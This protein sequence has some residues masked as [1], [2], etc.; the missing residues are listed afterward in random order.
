MFGFATQKKADVNFSNIGAGDSPAMIE[1]KLLSSINNVEK[2]IKYY[3]QRVESINDRFVSIED[4]TQKQLSQADES[5]A[6]ILAKISSVK[7]GKAKG[8][9]EI[10]A[11][12]EKGAHFIALR[13]KRL[14]E[15]LVKLG[16]LIYE[17]VGPKDVIPVSKVVDQLLIDRDRFEK[18]IE[19]LKSSIS[20]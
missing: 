10:L 19:T 8:N 1:R 16:K 12:V 11:E 9:M 15:E 5:E 3:A 2:K 4:K 20:I 18:K 14:K 13:K 7:G 6:A 17:D